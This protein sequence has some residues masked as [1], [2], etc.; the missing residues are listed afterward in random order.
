M[1]AGR[2]VPLGGPGK[3]LVNY[4]RDVR[5]ELRKVVWPTRQEALNLTMVTLALSLA[6]GLFL[7]GVDFIFQEFFRLLLGAF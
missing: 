2:R 7:G 5:I 6:V 3:A 4:L 1:V